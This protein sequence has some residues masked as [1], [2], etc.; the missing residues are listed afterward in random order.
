MKYLVTGAAGFIGAK[1]SE[2]LLKKGHDVVGIDIINDYY[3]VELKESR[4][5][6]LLKDS[7]FVF[8]KIDIA[9]SQDVLDLFAAEKFDRVVHLAAQ[10]GVRYSIENPMAYADSNLVGHLNILEG[11]R[12]NN[13]AH[14]V[15]ASS[16]SVYGLNAKTPFSTS[17]T[18][19][20][21]VSLYAATK[22]SNELMAHSYSHLYNMPTTGL[23]FFTVYGPCGRPDM[24][25]FIFTKKIL[26]GETIDINNNG[27]MWRDF[28][29]IDDI[30]EGVIRIADV[31]PAR[32]DDWTV[33]E[34]TPASSSAPYSVYNIG[35]GS[36]INLMD[37]IKAIEAE[38]GIE[39]TKN[40]RGMQP[41]DVYQTY[42]DTQDL[43]KATGYTPK[44]GV[45]EG[46]ANLVRWYKEFYNK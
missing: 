27:D 17:D 40:F 22:K 25:P 44:V 23:R 10:A 6:P 36:P 26:D 31:I 21:P 7:K 43:F 11:C 32:N 19:D 12:H 42:A 24:A 9:H 1:V 20:H 28:T 2:E 46:V 35:H 5:A 45:K 16:S 34:G 14:L 29:Y 39:A 33:E 37:F 3:D 30:V 4:L 18:V 38:L 15:Y 13:V 8:K 41:G